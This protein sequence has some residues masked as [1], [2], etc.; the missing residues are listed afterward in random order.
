MAIVLLPSGFCGSCC[1]NLSLSLSFSLTLFHMTCIFH[2]Y[3]VRMKKPIRSPWDHLTLRAT[4]LEQLSS[5]PGYCPW[6]EDLTRGPGVEQQLCGTWVQ[7]NDYLGWVG[8]VEIFLEFP[9]M[10]SHLAWKFSFLKVQLQMHWKRSIWNVIWPYFAEV[11]GFLPHWSL[12]CYQSS[13]SIFPWMLIYMH[14]SCL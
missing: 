10:N 2:F 1:F 4:L 7:V 11:S 9:Q 12:K 13:F 6:E 5:D 8:Y 3:W 14:M